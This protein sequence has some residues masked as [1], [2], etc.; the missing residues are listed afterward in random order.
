[1]V[2]QVAEKVELAVVSGIEEAERLPDHYEP[3][4]VEESLIRPRDLIEDELLLG[5]PQI[6]RHASGKCG[7]QVDR[8]FNPEPGAHSNEAN[9]FAVLAAMKRNNKR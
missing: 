6:P 8:G 3:L 7:L 9:P 1:M 5:L 2:H 4:L